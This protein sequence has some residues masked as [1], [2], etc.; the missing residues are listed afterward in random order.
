MVFTR[1]EVRRS[2]GR[3]GPRGGRRHV[4]SGEAA[5]EGRLRAKGRDRAVVAQ[6]EAARVPA[7]PC[8]SRDTQKRTVEATTLDTWSC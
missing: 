4:A 8:C 2:A 3:P 1:L 6:E 7:Q 5:E